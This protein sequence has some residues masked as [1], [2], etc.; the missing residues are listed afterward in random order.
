MLKVVVRI[1]SLKPGP[2]P[3]RRTSATAPG[4]IRVRIAPDQ[5]STHVVFFYTEAV[6]DTKG[7]AP[8]G[9]LLRIAN[10]PELFP[11]RL[12]RFRTAAG[13]FAQQLIKNLND[14]DITTD[15]GG[16]KIVSFSLA[17][18]AG[19]SWQVWACTL[20]SDGISS[21]PAGPWQSLVPVV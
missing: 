16:G 19:S 10:R 13:E 3:E 15:D 12:L 4:V 21:E 17:E 6:T 11:D 7:P 9:T 2:V 18:E 8:K 5:N 20:T 14:S 1:P